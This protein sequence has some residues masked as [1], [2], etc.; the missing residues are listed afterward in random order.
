MSDA[1][2]TERNY[3]LDDS[4]PFVS[5]I[6]PVFNDAKRLRSCLEALVAQNYPAG[7]WE[8]IVVDNGS[9]DNV[10]SV[11]ESFEF[12]QFAEAKKAGSYAAR[13]CGLDLARGE[14]VAFT[15]ADCIP[16][17]NWLSEGVRLLMDNAA[18]GFV[19]GRVEILPSDMRRP[20]A[21]ELYDM[22]FG[23]QQQLNIARFDH[24]ATAN[25]LTRREIF[26]RFGRFDDAVKSGGD[27][28]WGQRVTAGGYP[29]V[30]SQEAVVRHPARREWTAILRQTRR[31]AGGRF[32]RHRISDPYRYGSARFW[33][34]VWMR[35]FPNVGRMRHARRRLSALGYG[36]SDWL[37]VC[38]VALVLQY[39][40][41]VE[42]VTKWLGSS[43]ERR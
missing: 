40:S 32:D 42:F 30:Y 19:G 39:A 15:D 34:V 33:R 8:V 38:A 12:C 10:R 27:A 3:S 2:Q 35:F 25:M 9:Q 16:N 36:V 20:T 23:L 6:I 41:A 17:E 4:V 37:K 31:H 28:E 29:G 5:V 43:S 14:L 21:V 1:S 24:A 7:R 18:C 22:L 13:N 26:K 11:V